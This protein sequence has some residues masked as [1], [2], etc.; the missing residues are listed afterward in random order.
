MA[1]KHKIGVYT[2]TALVVANMVGTGVFTSLGFETAAL[3]SV[4]VLL[5]LWFC[6]GLVAL[7]G[8]LSYIELSRLMPGSGGEYHYIR[9]AYPPFFAHLAGAISVVS[10]F[11]APVALAAMAFGIY[12]NQL[13]PVFNVKLIALGIVTIITAMHSFHLKVGSRFQLFSTALKVLLLAAFIIAGL[14]YP[15]SHLDF[16]FGLAEQKMILSSGFSSSLVYVSFA[17]SGW[18]ASTYI[19]NEIRNPVKNIR[20]S[21]ICGTLLVTL[22]Y[23][24]LNLVF[25]KVVPMDQIH[26][27]VEIAAL[28]ATKILGITGGQVVALI[29]CLLLVSTISAMVWVGP[30]VIVKMAENSA[31]K[32]FNQQSKRNPFS[33]IL[34]QYL[35]T[36]LLLLTGTFEVILTYTVVC[37]NICSI[38]AVSILFLRYKSQSLG[39]LF[40]ATIFLLASIWSCVFLLLS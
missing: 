18:N 22:L 36:V 27:V 3:P 33:A 20:R 29:I 16:T 26:G 4:P 1:A 35:I 32:I 2:A 24:G 39:T 31:I 12:L 17:Y 19:F 21:I 9:Q 14:L 13:F 11:S 25:L 5:F 38:V 7:C 8:G 15:G 30:R 34:F 10:G 37:L 40:I 28:A 23:L 6:A